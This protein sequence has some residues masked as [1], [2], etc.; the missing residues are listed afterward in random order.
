MTPSP[1]TQGQSDVYEWED[2]D[3][4]RYRILPSGRVQHWEQGESGGWFY[5]ADEDP[6]SIKLYDLAQELKAKDEV[7]KKVEEVAEAIEVVASREGKVVVS[8]VRPFLDRIA[9]TLRVALQPKP[10]SKT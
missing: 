4:G 7:I 6:V 5:Y 10:G 9:A 2:D 1:A 3:G 8:E